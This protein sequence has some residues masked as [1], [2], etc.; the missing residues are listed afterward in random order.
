MTAVRR[1]RQRAAAVG[2][3]LAMAGAASLATAGPASATA[4]GT[5]P[6]GSFSYSFQGATIKVPTG[7]FLTHR[8]GGSGKKIK[9]EMAGVDCAGPAAIFSKFCN[10]RMDFTYA[11]TSN[12]V[13]KTS[14]GKTHTECKGN[15]LRHGKAQT[16]PKYGKACAKFYVNGVHKAT[17]CHFIKK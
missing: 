16:L 4:V 2:G 12:K 6:I 11:N 5:T 7:C 10:W 17:Q 3:A 13:Y 9:D 14:K 8:I 15:P 1:W